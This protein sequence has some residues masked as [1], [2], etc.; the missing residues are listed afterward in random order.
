VTHSEVKGIWFDSA[1]RWLRRTRGPDAAA[2]L[3]A[4][5]S[6][7][8]RGILLDP[9]VFDWYPEAALGDLLAAVRVELT[10][11]SA[12]AFVHIIEEI[13]LDGVG[14]FFRLVLS[15]ASPSFV[16]RKVPILWGRMRRGAGRVEVD[17]TLQR[18]RLRYRDFPYF[19]DE[20]YRLM[21][22]ATLGGVCRAAGAKAPSVEIVAWTADSLDVDVR[23]AR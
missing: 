21:T 6:E 13:T 5:V 11:G 12:G 14:R 9:V 8:H 2:R 16:L 19:D 17:A 3:D 23:L 4:L 22:V 1:A 7:A 18:V 15:L 20:N 10:D